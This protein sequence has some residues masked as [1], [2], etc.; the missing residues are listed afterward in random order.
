M[1]RFFKRSVEGN[2]RNWPDV[3]ELSALQEQHFKATDAQRFRYIWCSIADICGV[4][5]LK[6]NKNAQLV[7]LCPPPSRWSNIN[8]RLDD[9]EEFALRESRG[10][11]IPENLRTVGALVEWLLGDEAR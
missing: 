10:R 7:D 3:R 6:L 2:E 1:R 4:P 5:P 8:E 9:I 11:L